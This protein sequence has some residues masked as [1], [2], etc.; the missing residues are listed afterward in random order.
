MT[1]LTVEQRRSLVEWLATH[2]MGWDVEVTQDGKRGFVWPGV[3]LGLVLWS[4]YD[5]ED[6]PFW[7]PTI[8]WADAGMCWTKV[9]EDLGIVADMEQ[10]LFEQA[11]LVEM[12][13]A[14]LEWFLQHATPLLVSLAIFY[15]TG[16][17]FDGEAK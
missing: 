16:G 5:D 13:A 6:Y 15:A 8:S 9:Q 1:D 12:E 3:G 14:T 11:H 4:P 2:A 10:W 7:N 17:K